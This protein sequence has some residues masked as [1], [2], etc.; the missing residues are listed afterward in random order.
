MSSSDSRQDALPWYR[1]FWPWFLMLIPAV[2]VLGGVATLLIAM[3][4]PDG[5]VADDYY[6]SGLA[7]NQDLSRD[8]RARELGLSAQAVLD[9]DLGSV[10]ITV[11]SGVPLGVDR[12]RLSLV[13]PTRA[14]TDVSVDLRR[15]HDQ[16]FAA[17][18]GA[19]APGR[20]HVVIE[21]LDST[22]RLRG[23]ISLPGQ[24]SMKLQPEQGG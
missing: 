10:A 7:I 8:A 3:S 13:H 6:K 4:E 22:W 9:P 24:T 16:S 19:L 15:V 12:L 23:R 14:G 11:H 2:A 5:L 17:E 21:P 1:Q 20:W 18:I